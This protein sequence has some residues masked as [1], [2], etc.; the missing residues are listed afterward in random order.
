M[1]NIYF[2]KNKFDYTFTILQKD[3]DIIKNKYGFTMSYQININY[4]FEVEI[5]DIYK[6]RIENMFSLGNDIKFNWV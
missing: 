4:D 5:N 1:I 6:K 2:N 3:I